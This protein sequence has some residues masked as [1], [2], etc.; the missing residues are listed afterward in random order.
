M[1]NEEQRLNALHISRIIDSEDEEALENLAKLVSRI[2][3]VPIGMINFIDK[4]KQWTKS[5]VGWDIKEMPR[6][7]SFCSHT[8][9]EEENYMIVPDAKKDK[10]FKD[11]IYVKGEPNIRFYAGVNV[12]SPDGYR[13]GTICAIGRKP[14]K[15]SKHQLEGL[16]IF[17]KEVET[18]LKLRLNKKELEEMKLFEMTI[19]SLPVNFYM[20]DSDGNIIH[21]NDN[22]RKTTGYSNDEIAKMSPL[23]YFP[24]KEKKR[25]QKH[26]DK[27]LKEGEASLES[28]I[29]K[30]DGTTAPFIF[31]ASRF[32]NKDK[33]Y[34][35]GTSQDISEQKK[36]QQQLQE[37]LKEKNVLL[38]EIHHRV[39][40]NLAIIYSL[41]RLEELNG[42]SSDEETLLKTCL[43][44]RSIALIH[45]IMY[46]TENFIH[47]D[48]SQVIESITDH[49]KEVYSNGS[50]KINFTYNIDSFPLNINQ[51]IPCGLIVNEL[52][53]NSWR[54]AFIAREKGNI[55]IGFVIQDGI[56][57]LRVKDDGVG[58]P[59]HIKPES[60]K[61]VGFLLVQQLSGQLNSNVQVQ[62]NG[63]TEFIITFEKSDVKGSGSAL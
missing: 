35:I 4:N 41:I 58:L 49:I 1:N 37:S 15:L 62:R 25:I 13:L 9:R 5:S 45:E 33:T 30:K 60:S 16:Q 18:H 31:S 22:I 55:K 19:N 44:I 42:H 24:E 7:D 40:N 61:S 34:L 27:V 56:I 54:H 14:K 52:V 10:R 57:T 32:T 36:T 51:A 26:F 59:D 39:K 2:C 11:S 6:E 53:A 12:H 28:E 23:D 63:G 21:W 8:I 43:R 50:D 3:D 29:Q 46:K 38:A 47:I 48:F 20:Y 17:A